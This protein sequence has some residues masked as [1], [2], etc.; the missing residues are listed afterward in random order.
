MGFSDIHP[1]PNGPHTLRAF[2]LACDCHRQRTENPRVDGS[3]EDD[4]SRPILHV[5]STRRRLEGFS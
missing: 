2:F 1:H 5:T 3:I 4:R